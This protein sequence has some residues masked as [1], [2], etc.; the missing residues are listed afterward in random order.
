MS[1]GHLFSQ[2]RELWGVIALGALAGIGFCFV[3]FPLDDSLRMAAALALAGASAGA[4]VFLL[5][6]T[7]QSRGW[8][9]A[10]LCILSAGAIGGAVYWFV[11][12]PS[13]SVVN[14]L[15]TGICAVAALVLLEALVSRAVNRLAKCVPTE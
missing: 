12:R 6:Y 1:Q 14:S 15:L 3:Y 5:A 13:C 9:F 8:P 7:T 4:C 10:I 2:L 11:A